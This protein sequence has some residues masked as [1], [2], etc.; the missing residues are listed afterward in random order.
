MN[1]L[2]GGQSVRS[3]ACY[4]MKTWILLAFAAYAVQACPKDVMSGVQECMRPLESHSVGQGQIIEFMSRLD[5]TMQLCTEGKIQSVFSCLSD[6][7]NRC[8]RHKGSGQKQDLGLLVSVGKWREAMNNICN[9]MDYFKDNAECEK[10][11]SLEFIPCAET[12]VA[13][14]NQKYSV[15]NNPKHVS[16]HQRMDETLKIGCHLTARI[17]DCLKKPFKKFCPDHLT[18]LLVKI[19][20]SFKPPAC[21]KRSVSNGHHGHSSR[22]NISISTVEIKPPTAGNS[23]PIGVNHSS[24]EASRSSNSFDPNSGPTLKSYSNIGFLWL[25]VVSLIFRI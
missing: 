23:K 22:V 17:L 14:A 18:N 20:E 15:I 19:F 5:K 11:A 10:N 8:A 7:Y 25:F 24:R 9:N 21:A 16:E 12:E 3:L 6:L 4:D 2:V 1:I 13:W